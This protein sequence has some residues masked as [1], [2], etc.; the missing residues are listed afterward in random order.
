LIRQT[1]IFQTRT[2]ALPYRLC[3]FPVQDIQSMTQ[4]RLSGEVM[5]PDV[6]QDQLVL[7][8]ID[9]MHSHKCE[10]SIRKSVQRCRG[11][12]EIETDFASGQASILFEKRLVSVRDLMTAIEDAGYHATG[13]A[14]GGA[15]EIS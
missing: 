3:R 5:S 14:L 4:S 9:G 2:L 8:R 11:V 1:G 10:Q 7:I 15:E 12:F 13:H 6:S